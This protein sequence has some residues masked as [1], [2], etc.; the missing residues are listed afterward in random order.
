MAI[1]PCPAIER[2]L[3]NCPDDCL[4]CSLETEEEA[5]PVTK[6]WLFSILNMEPAKD[7]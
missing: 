7:E 4:L 2:G 5:I 6:E 1:D 3:Y